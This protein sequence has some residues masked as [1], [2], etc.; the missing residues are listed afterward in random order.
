MS[1]LLNLAKR[2]RKNIDN[3]IDYLKSNPNRI[4]SVVQAVANPVGFAANKVVNKAVNTPLGPNKISIAQANQNLVSDSRFYDNYRNLMSGKKALGDNAYTNTVGRYI[5]NFATSLPKVA[6]VLTDKTASI[7]KKGGAALESL[8]AYKTAMGGFPAM[9]GSLV[10]P[11]ISSVLKTVENKASGKPLKEGLGEAWNKGQESGYQIKGF[12]TLSNPALSKAINS[13]PLSKLSSKVPASNVVKN[14]VLP[15]AANVIE[16][17]GMDKSLGQPTTPMSIAFDAVTGAIGGKDQF[18]IGKGIERQRSGMHPQDASAVDAVID[19]LRNKKA[20][21]EDKRKALT[22]LDR[23]AEHYLSKTE[24]NKLRSSQ[25]TITAKDLRIARELQKR[26]GSVADFSGYQIG[27]VEKGKPIADTPTVKLEQPVQRGDI[28]KLQKNLDEVLGTKSFNASGKWNHD[29]S[30]RET[31]KKQLEYFAESDPEARALLK[32]V[33]NLEESIATAQDARMKPKVP[34]KSNLEPDDFTTPKQI[35]NKKRFDPNDPSSPGYA[36]I[37]GYN[38]LFHKGYSKSQLD[39]MGH[40]EVAKA[41][42]EDIPPFEHPSFLKVQQS[43]TKGKV[44]LRSPQLSSDPNSS[45]APQIG[46]KPIKSGKRYEQFAPTDEDIDQTVGLSYLNEIEQNSL[47]RHFNKI[48]NPIKNA[49][50]VVQD[51][52]QRWRNTNIGA[53]VKANQVAQMFTDIPEKDGWKL[54]QYIQDPTNRN[55]MELDLDVSQYTPQIKRIRQFYDTTR[56]EGIDAGLEVGYLE[57]Y[58][59]QI[60]KETPNKISEIIKAGAG[61]NPSWIKERVIP[62]YQE[63]VKIGLT[64][65]F[66]HPAQLAAHYRLQLDKALTNR[67]MVDELIQTELL[68][69]ASGAPM[70]WKTINSPFFPKVKVKFGEGEDVIMD[71]KAPKDIATAL[72]NIFETREPG[73]MTTAAGISKGMQD[74]TLSAGIPFTPWNSFTLAHINK[75]VQSGRIKGPAVASALS[76]SDKWSRNYFIKNQDAIEDMASEGIRS[77]NNTDYTDLYKN[78]AEQSSGLEKVFNGA[79]RIFNSA[80]NEPTFKRFMPILQIEF[81]KDSY[82]GAIDSGLSPQ[83]AKRIAAQATKNFNGISDVFSRSGATEDAMSAT[84]LAPAFREAMI[85]FWG[86]T[87]KSIDPRTWKDPA[88]KSNRKYLVGLG[89]SYALYNGINYALTGKPMWENKPGKET[90]VEIPLGGGRSFFTPLSPTISTVPRRFIEGA[91]NLLGGDIAG[92]TERMSSFASIPVQTLSSVLTNRTFYGGPIYQDDDPALTKLGKLAGYAVEQNAHPWLGEPIAISQGRKTPLESLPALVEV[93]FY[94]SASS[95]VAH[96]KG[97]SSRKFKEL[98]SLNPAAAHAYSER[99][100]AQGQMKAAKASVKS[101]VKQKE[102]GFFQKLFNRQPKEATPDMLEAYFGIT[103]YDL[104]PQSTAMQRAQ[105]E[106]ERTKIVDSILDDEDVTPE[107]KIQ[108]LSKMNEESVIDKND[109]EY[110]QTASLTNDIKT[111]FVKD[112]LSTTTPEDRYEALILL[113]QEVNGKSVLSSGVLTNIYKEGL[114]SKAEQNTLKNVTY[115]KKTGDLIRKSGTSGRSKK[116]NVKGS[117]AVK[118][119]SNTPG[120]INITSGSSGRQQLPSVKLNIP[121]KG[122]QFST[123]EA[124]A[125]NV[126]ELLK[127]ATLEQKPITYDKQKVKVKIPKRA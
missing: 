127:S 10:A 31:A 21:S 3:E 74:I 7:Q 33:N 62:S 86:N 50:P 28:T 22:T 55:A 92:A 90:S 59:N 6:P 56:Q 75:E 53:R 73:I 123:S 2:L 38:D 96:L 18:A 102:P 15:T 14:R 26:A 79:K 29:L 88:F 17:I 69:P 36:L 87:I 9:V 16:G 49:P 81:F 106:A 25:K 115:D 5:G 70:D 78:L 76:L 119:P 52:M 68:L 101:E 13:T 83:E 60:W 89:I 72:N 95:D 121:T 43:K 80:F 40:E 11:T 58:L 82:K 93:P 111:G 66:T 39:I 46:N 100:K 47:K 107:Q 104:L 97:A 122:P 117:I 110:Y 65:K 71:Y 32:Y 77:W 98:Y 34:V 8:G 63:G 23:L 12:T 42:K 19:T 84:L 67:K 44:K 24:I 94:P 113:T 85:N 125:N 64:P 109:I 27:L 1:S 54:I 48:F 99:M 124:T 118:L 105:K 126:G 51:I 4:H 61:K 116:V 112:Y 35:L 30:A 45:F 57:N 91:G 37:K 20:T 114:I 41:L 120:K 103:E 108:A